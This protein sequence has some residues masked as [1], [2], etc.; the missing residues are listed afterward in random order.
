MLDR[1]PIYQLTTEQKGIRHNITCTIIWLMMAEWTTDRVTKAAP[2]A[3]SRQRVS[4]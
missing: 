3:V 4:R 2:P 1:L